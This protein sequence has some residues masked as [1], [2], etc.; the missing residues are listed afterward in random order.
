M[1][2]QKNSSISA[3]GYAWAPYW[4]RGLVALAIG[5]LIYKVFFLLLGVHLEY[6]AGLASFNMS[7]ILSMSVLPVGVGI[8][9]GLIYGFGAKYLAHFPPA[10]VMLWDYQHVSYADMPAGGHLLPWGLWI[11][12]VIL[13]ME[14]CAVGGFIGE[15]LIRKR[16]AWDNGVVYT[17]DSEALPDDE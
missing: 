6:F 3:V 16:H 14:F 12:F 5:A 9:I 7:W 17:A 13:Q 4:V 10:I 8:V 15:I 1:N 2:N 11:M